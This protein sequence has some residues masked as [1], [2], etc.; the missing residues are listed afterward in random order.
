LSGPAELEKA[1]IIYGLV[2]IT[3]EYSTGLNFGEA[4]AHNKS[5]V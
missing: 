3:S 1:P 5:F 4:K 2:V